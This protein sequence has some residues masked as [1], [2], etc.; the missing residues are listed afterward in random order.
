LLKRMSFYLP[1]FLHDSEFVQCQ[2]PLPN[3]PL[4]LSLQSVPVR[5]ASSMYQW[6]RT[7]GI[8]LVRWQRMQVLFSMLKVRAETFFKQ[9]M[10]DKSSCDQEGWQLSEWGFECVFQIQG[11]LHKIFSQ[12]NLKRKKEKVKKFDPAQLFEISSTES[13]CPY[14]GCGLG[15]WSEKHVGWWLK[16]HS[17]LDFDRPGMCIKE[18][19]T[20]LDMKRFASHLISPR[21]IFMQ[22]GS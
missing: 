7:P 4:S 14:A 19:G 5:K 1:W 10:V 20:S 11:N 22:S 18:R 21:I 16:C 6:Q 13:G 2:L 3:T 15:G 17:L 8:W 12:F 9:C